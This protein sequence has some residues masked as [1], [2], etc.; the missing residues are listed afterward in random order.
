MALPVRD[1]LDKGLSRLEGTSPSAKR[2]RFND[3]VAALP[4]AEKE[5]KEHTEE[6]AWEMTLPAEDVIRFRFGTHA[7]IPAVGGEEGD[8]DHGGDLHVPLFTHQILTEPKE[9]LTF[10]Q[11][12]AIDLK[13]LIHTCTRSLS[14]KVHWTGHVSKQDRARLQASLDA[15]LPPPD[16]PACTTL[17][18]AWP[19]LARF[20]RGADTFVMYRVTD[21]DEGAACLLAHSERLAMW[22]VHARTCTHTHMH[23]HCLTLCLTHPLTY[24]AG[25]LRPPR[26]WISLTR[27]GRPFSASALVPGVAE[28]TAAARTTMSGT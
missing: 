9:I 20:I 6:P 3:S 18:N 25:T 7:P 5:T 11:S 24:P 12:C 22:Y 28:V 2:V 4:A 1:V 8:G 14:T 10:S 17:V 19:E 16:T 21:K 23:I 15:A 13:V 27:H 26:Q